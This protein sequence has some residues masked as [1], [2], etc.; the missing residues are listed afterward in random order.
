[1]IPFQTISRVIKYKGCILLWTG[2][3]FCARLD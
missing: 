1:M 3:R 2:D